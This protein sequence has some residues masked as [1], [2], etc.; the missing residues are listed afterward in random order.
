MWASSVSKLVMSMYTLCIL[1]VIVGKVGTEK[2]LK[3]EKM[4]V[5]S[6]TREIKALQVVKCVFFCGIN[7][8]G[9]GKCVF[10]SK[11]YTK[12]TAKTENVKKWSKCV[13]FD[14]FT[15]NFSGWITLLCLFVI[16]SFIFVFLCVR[17]SSFV[18]FVKI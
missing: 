12:S 16:F 17:K 8:F 10:I 1:H 9:P 11:I 2:A 7:T 18:A 6:K 4:C 14:W 5:F 15:L 13:F 3:C